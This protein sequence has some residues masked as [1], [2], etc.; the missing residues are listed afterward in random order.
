MIEQKQGKFPC[1]VTVKGNVKGE[2]SFVF[3]T[4]GAHILWA[5]VYGFALTVLVML[6]LLT[7]ILQWTL[8]HFVVVLFVKY[9]LLMLLLLLWTVYNSIL[10]SILINMNIHIVVHRTNN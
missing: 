6:L 5:Y 8:V 9:I 2:W 10:Y 7:S 3:L 4:S 1:Q